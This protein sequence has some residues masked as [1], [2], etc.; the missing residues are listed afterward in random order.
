MT[1]DIFDDIAKLRLP[2]TPALELAVPPPDGSTAKQSSR[3]K[4]ST[5]PFVKR[6]LTWVEG[7]QK[8]KHAA[9]HAVADFVLYEWWRKGEPV[10]VSNVALPAMTRWQKARAI[11]ELEAL[12]LVK[13]ERQGKQAP[14][15]TPPAGLAL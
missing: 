9:T 15:V 12:G 3:Q 1:D 14:R 13:V 7:L 8:A 4:K 6:P 11:S 5:A 10:T 2:G